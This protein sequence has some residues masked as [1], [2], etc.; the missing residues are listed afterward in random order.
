MRIAILPTRV[1]SQRVRKPLRSPCRAQELHGLGL[2]GLLDQRLQ[3]RAKVVDGRREGRA[4]GLLEEPL[5]ATIRNRNGHWSASGL[6][7]AATPLV[8]KVTQK[9]DGGR[10]CV[11]R[12]RPPPELHTIS[13]TTNEGW[14][15]YSGL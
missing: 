4:A 12:S 1:T 6:R 15:A 2:H 7:G 3:H 9:T 13:Y 10:F 8:N 11:Q 5:W 14:N